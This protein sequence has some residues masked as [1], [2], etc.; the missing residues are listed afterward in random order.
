M[1]VKNIPGRVV[2]NE[3]V[4]IC[5]H[6]VSHKT[7][8]IWVK[9]PRSER[10]H[11]PQQPRLY[12]KICGRLQYTGSAYARD[13]GFYVNMLKE[14]KQKVD[15]LYKRGKARNKLT[16]THLRL[17]V[18]DLKNDPDFLDAFSNQEYSQYDFFKACVLKHSSVEEYLIDSIYEQMK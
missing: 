12:C 10:K 17:I 7:E 16:Q 9:P 18:D 13:L 5:E 15:V 8:S 11:T 4:C 14:L 6:D 1:S 3:P 2:E